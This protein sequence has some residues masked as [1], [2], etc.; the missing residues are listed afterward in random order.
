MTFKK[1][2]SEAGV[3]ITQLDPRF[4]S[5]ELLKNIHAE[6]NKTHKEDHR[7]KLAVFL[8]CVSG[9]LP[10]PSDHCSAALKGDSAAGKD[11]LLHTCLR[12]LPE[13]DTFFLTR[14]TTAALEQE[15]S[16][17]RI[18]AFSEINAHREKGANSDLTETFKQF[19]EGG[20]D[21]MK[22]DPSTGFKFPLRIKTEQK[23]LLYGTT[24]TASD[25]ELETRYVIVPV[26][27]DKHKNKIVVDAVL[28]AASTFQSFEQKKQKSW[29]A[30]GLSLLDSSLHVVIPYSKALKESVEY[31]DGETRPFFDFTKERIKR[32]VKRLLSLTRAISWLHQKQRLV[33]DEGEGKQYI[34]A[35]PSDFIT[36]VDIFMDFFDLTY[37]GLDFRIQRTLDTLRN[38]QGKHDAEIIKAGFDISR[39]SG[40]I[41]RHLLAKE[42]G[43]ASN[44]TIKE[45]ISVLKDRGFIQDQHYDPS[46]PRAYLLKPAPKDRVSIGYQQGIRGYQLIASDTLLAPYLIPSKIKEVYKGKTINHII[47]T[48][49]SDFTVRSDQIEALKIDTL[50]SPRNI[51]PFPVEMEVALSPCVVCGF[52]P[53]RSES[54]QCFITNK[55]P[56]CEVCLKSGKEVQP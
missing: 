26:R 2:A 41:M 37:S 19:A 20:V 36:A 14:A 51:H 53:G 5:P 16:Q 50:N 30:E 42:L 25:D 1:L 56:V 11:N 21:V 13:Q 32:D 39:Y 6:L 23:S 7:E 27:S 8:V 38:L 31:P 4:K 43:I 18:I 49:L 9:Y 3:R 29:I 33:E 24:E 35:E 54:G 22:M 10:D 55:G 46:I 52:D 17:V 44:S 40:F 28:D 15:A 12:H 34:L 48:F 45:H 47:R